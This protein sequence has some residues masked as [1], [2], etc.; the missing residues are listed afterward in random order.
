MATNGEPWVNLFF[1]G[2]LHY[3]KVIQGRH[4]ER[5]SGSWVPA[6]NCG[7]R[8]DSLYMQEKA[9]VETR[10]LGLLTWDVVVMLAG[11]KSYS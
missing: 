6:M 5:V 4:S 11:Q 7:Q 1:Q 8:M 2:D 10:H 9:Q 3:G